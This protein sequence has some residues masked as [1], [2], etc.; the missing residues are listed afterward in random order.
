MKEKQKHNKKHRYHSIL[1]VKLTVLYPFDFYVC[2]YSC[3]LIKPKGTIS[4][5]LSQYIQYVPNVF[6]QRGI[7][8]VAF[9]DM[10]NQLHVTI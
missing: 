10:M 8:G 5:V 4:A 6:I 3:S 1:F 2:F 7:H 9:F